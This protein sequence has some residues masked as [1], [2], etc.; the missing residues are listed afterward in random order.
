MSVSRP[1]DPSADLSQDTEHAALLARIAARD[2][3]SEAAMAQLYRALQGNVFAFVRR[4]LSLADDHEVQAV[5]VDTMYEVW[6]AAPQF[7]G[8]SQVKTWVLGIARHKLLDAVRK[9]P[10]AQRGYDDIADHADTL[11]DESAD[12]INQLAEQ[13]RAEWLA[14]CLDKL[15]E[16]QRESLHLLLV[17]G[18]S[19]EDI[20]QVQSCPGGTVKTRVFHAKAKLKSCLAR[21]LK[22]EE[23]AN[24]QAPIKAQKKEDWV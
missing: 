23:P 12:I 15:P 5:V 11:P 1:P 17:E 21:W 18:M 14:Y 2:A 7:A 24:M 13:Q 4:R 8:S 20:A 16:E 9:D 19:V 10:H 22:H 3:G 6:R